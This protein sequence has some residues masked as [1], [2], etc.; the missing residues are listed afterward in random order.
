MDITETNADGLK[1]EF[2]IMVPAGQIEER[3]ESKLKELAQTIRMPG[4]R[5]GKV[6]LPMLRKKYRASVMGEVLE[7]EIND[8]TQKA[9][10]DGGLRPAMQPK[11]E[12]TSFKEGEDLEFKVELETLPEVEPIDFATIEVERPKVEIA[13]AEVDTALGRIA[14]RNEKTEA[15][16]AEHKAETGD[17]I[18]IDFTGKRD[19]EPFQGGA[20]Q[21]YQL[22]L[23][24][25]SF[26]P[27][28]EEQLVGVAAGD[29]K[30]IPLTF[31]EQYHNAELAGQPVDFDVKVHEVRRAQ[32]PSIDDEFAKTLGLDD[33][34]GLRKAVREQIEREYGSLSRTIVKRRLLDMLAEKH[35]FTVPQGMVDVEFEHIWKQVEQDKTQG[36]LDPEDAGKDEDTLK[37]EYRDI[38]ERRVRLGLLLSEVGR[39]NNITVTQD[40]I[41]RA[42]VDEARRFPGQEGMVF[43]YYQK[44]PDALNMLKA[45]I[46]EDKV[47]DFV[48]ELA[49][50]TDKP[51]SP[52]EL[53]KLAEGAEKAQA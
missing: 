53:T 52:E 42:V 44:N 28:F 23:G 13:E 32:T 26:I 50:T 43:Q 15:L 17:V 48:L 35:D 4:F 36:R 19:G 3:V 41:N 51:V 10:T 5:P 2:K 31:P 34:E 45:P 40:D 11:I 49:K 39:R 16:P 33:L 18:V 38:A 37:K 47:V 8:A 22:K 46:Y 30:T 25:G 1:R 24:S 6:P 12:I 29:E 21:S 20:A 9:I 7:S 14:E 27:G